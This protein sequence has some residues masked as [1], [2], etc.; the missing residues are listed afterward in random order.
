LTAATRI[1]T[2]SSRVRTTVRTALVSAEYGAAA[3]GVS[4]SLFAP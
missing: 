2:R 1:C 4:A 3:V